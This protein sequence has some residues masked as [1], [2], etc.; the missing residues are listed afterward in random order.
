M[1]GY[2]VSFGHKLMKF[3]RKTAKRLSEPI[4]PG[5]RLIVYWK[6]VMVI[7]VMLQSILCTYAA[8]FDTTANVSLQNDAIAWMFCLDIIFVADIVLTFRTG[9][10]H[11][12][13]LIK[14]K[15]SIAGNY[16]KNTFLIDILS[17]LSLLSYFSKVSPYFL[18]F[19]ML[20]LYH[21]PNHSFTIEEYFQF[22]RRISSLFKVM[23][24]VILVLLIAHYFACIFY[25]VT[26][27]ESLEETWLYAYG[28][29]TKPNEDKYVASLYFTVTTMATIGYGDIVPKSRKER[30]VNIAVMITASILFGYTL[31]SIGSL[32]LEISNYS[33][34]A[35]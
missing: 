17:L 31:S 19:P 29:D 15:K 30:I 28:L 21:I 16:L 33:S 12:G 7:I 18:L 2:K 23:K 13:E 24:L 32:I 4:R 10:Y 27:D 3:A 5:T 26:K 6:I 35:K 1:Q 20:R 11:Q 25:A 34:E 8:S 14:K 22:G 9:Y